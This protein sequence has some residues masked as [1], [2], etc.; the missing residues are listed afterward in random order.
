MIHPIAGYA[1]RGAVWYQGE[2]NVGRYQEYPRMF[3]AMHDAWTKRWGGK[4]FPIYLCQIAP[5]RFSDQAGNAFLRE[6]QMKIAQTQSDTGIAILMDTGEQNCIHPA[7]KQVAANVS[8]ISHW[9]VTTDSRI[10]LP[11][12]G[13]PPCGVRRRQSHPHLRSYGNRF[14]LIRATVDRIRTCRRRSGFPS[15]N[16]LDRQRKDRRGIAAGAESHRCPIRLQGIHQR[17]A[18]RVQR[19]SC[20][21][22]PFGRLG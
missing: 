1:I 5:F 7:N 20:L 21:F 15:G 13:I 11:C 22:V 8:P 3:A 12:P 6:A 14:H 9:P 10:A 16:G 2:A 18:L 17:F 4:R 19:T